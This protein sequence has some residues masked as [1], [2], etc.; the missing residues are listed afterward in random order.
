MQSTFGILLKRDLRLSFRALSDVMNPLLFF[1]MVI[2]LFPLGI[3]SDK[4]QL[5]LIGS[6]V[7]WV[8][9]LLAVM[10][11]LDQLFKRDFQDGSLEQLLLAPI[12]PVMMV[13][14]K[15]I[16]FWMVVALPL[17]I[18]SPMLG[19][20]FHL[21]GEQIQ[22]LLISLLLGTP[23]LC[24]IGAIGAA[25][26]VNVKNGGVLIVLLVL[27]LYVPV[28]IFGA[29]TVLGVGQGL[30]VSGLLALLGALFCLSLSLAPIAISA[31]LKVTVGE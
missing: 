5:S 16:A 2:S 27:P 3:T 13:F 15:L 12:N 21:S 23:V 14:A 19:Y 22:M 24:A 7:V 26:T 30:D 11:S 17:V 29:G 1:V 31:G 6:G 28:L 20:M 9:S 18:V 8:S 25:L 4:E 10:L